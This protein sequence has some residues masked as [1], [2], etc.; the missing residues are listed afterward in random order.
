MTR[1]ERLAQDSISQDQ[2]D[3]VKDK[4]SAALGRNLRQLR[5]KRGFSL[6]R[7]AVISQVSRAMLG[8][9]ETGKSAPTINTVG[10]I[11]HALKVS[12]STLLNGEAPPTTVVKLQNV[13]TSLMTDEGSPSARIIAAWRDLSGAEVHE[14]SLAQGRCMS[15]APASEGI[16]KSL[17]VTAG[18]L[19][20]EIDD[21]PAITLSEGDAVIFCANQNHAL[22]SLGSVETRALLVIAGVDIFNWQE[23]RSFLSSTKADALT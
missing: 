4:L 17:F 10:L 5:Q 18:T 9:I 15:F 7:L 1:K 23:E 16:K 22:R 20:I 3:E 21:E 13:A 12:I 6:E 11:A 2:Q 8:Q 14:I 19:G